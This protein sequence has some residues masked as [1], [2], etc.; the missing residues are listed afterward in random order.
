MW[1]VS[2]QDLAATDAASARSLLFCGTGLL[3]DLDGAGVSLY[4]FGMTILLGTFGFS[5]SLPCI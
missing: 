2:L 5:S 3:S 1:D 4:D